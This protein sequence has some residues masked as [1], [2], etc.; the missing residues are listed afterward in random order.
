M[1]RKVFNRFSNSVWLTGIWVML[2]FVFKA[3]PAH[4]QLTELYSFQ[5]NSSTTGNYPDGANPMVELIQRADG[6]YYTTTDIGGAGACPGPI[7]GQIP[8]CGAVVKITP[9]GT[10]SVLHSFPYDTSTQ[11]APNGWFPQAG[12]VQGPDGGKSAPFVVQ[13]SEFI[14]AT[15]PCGATSG[16]IKMTT[17][18]GTVTSTKSF[19][20]LP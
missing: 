17:P 6:N 15:V 13:G 16:L 2:L 5:H 11:S 20:V 7:E 19:T 3:I 10:L 12:L 1:R 14:V 8:G 4:A 18:G 9:A